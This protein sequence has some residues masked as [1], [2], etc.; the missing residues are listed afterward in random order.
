MT[1]QQRYD[2]MS[3]HSGV[4]QTPRLDR[5]AAEGIDFRQFYSHSAPFNV[6]GDYTK[7]IRTQ[8]WKYVWYDGFEEL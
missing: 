5:A 1:D 2:A 7:T 6:P 8:R 4:A 3:C